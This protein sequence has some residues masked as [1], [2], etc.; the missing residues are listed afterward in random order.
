M[1]L[2]FEWNRRKAATNLKKH[3]V[4]F[5]E[6]AS[7]VAEAQAQIFPDEDH[8]VGEEREI[9]VGYSSMTRL[10]LVCFTEI[11]RGSGS[12]AHAALPKKNG[13]IMKNTARSRSSEK[14]RAT[15]VPNT[16]SIT[17]NPSLT[18]SRVQ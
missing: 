16:I 14:K 2:A 11:G 1:A 17:Q 3:S 8:S 5:E 18:D 12:S 6:A 7:V 4:S 15:C 13:A 10:L 9:I